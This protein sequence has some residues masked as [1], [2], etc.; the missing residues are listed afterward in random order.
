MQGFQLRAVEKEETLYDSIGEGLPYFAVELPDGTELYTRQMRG[1][2]LHFG[3]EVG[4]QRVAN[5][6]LSPMCGAR[7]TCFSGAALHAAVIIENKIIMEY[8]F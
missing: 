4:L 8:D 1:F 7:R 6:T 2:P 3:R 5:A